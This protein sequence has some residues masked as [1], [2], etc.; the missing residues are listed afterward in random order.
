MDLPWL[1]IAAAGVAAYIFSR[2][3]R[4]AFADADLHLLSL[5]DHKAN[6]FVGKVVWVTGA[7]QGLGS[8]LVSHM[9]AHG[10]RLILSSRS[11]ANLE[12][13]IKMCHL[14]KGLEPKG[15]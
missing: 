11:K 6:A 5:G 10:A 8:V 12:V 3:V 14:F 13:I 4:F 15:M 2:I 9:A 1:A 7:S